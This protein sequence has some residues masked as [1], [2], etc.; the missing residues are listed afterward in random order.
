MRRLRIGIIDIVANSPSNSWYARVMRANLAAIMPQV[1]GVWC[2]EL[3]HDVFLAYHSGYQNL[4]EELPEDLDVVFMGSFTTSAHVAYALSN[5]HRSKGAVTVL[6]GPH[7][8]AYPE[9]AQ[10]YFDF[11]LGFTDKELIRDILQ[12]CS[13]HRPLGSIGSRPRSSSPVGA[14]RRTGIRFRGN[15]GLRPLDRPRRRT[16]FGSPEK[17]ES[18]PLGIHLSAASQP[19][20]LPGLRQRWTFVER[21]LREAPVLKFVSMIGSLGCPYSCSFCSDSVVP[22]QPLDFEV[23]KDDLRFLRTKMNRPR[24]GWHDPHFGVR[25]HDFMDALE[26]GA[27]PCSVEVVG[28]RTVALRS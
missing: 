15:A 27:P 13:G 25:F 19:M 4:V 11:V 3:G 18:R 26:A 1:V 17:A 7:A 20:S 2:G 22:Y 5:F 24:V 28:V 6:G 21:L 14:A 10:K 23:L 16:E 12:D 9:D 8:R